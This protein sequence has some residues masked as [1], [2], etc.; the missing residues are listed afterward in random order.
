EFNSFNVIWKD[1][2]NETHKEPSNPYSMTLIQGIQYFKDKLQIR[3]HFIYGR[4]ELICFECEFDKCKPPLASKIDDKDVLLHD[5]YKHLS[6]YPIIQVYWEI[7]ACFMIPYKRTICV[8]RNN[9]PNS[10]PFR[11]AFILSNQR[12]NFNPLPYECDFHKL[13]IIQDTIYAKIIRNNALQKLLHEVIKNDYLI[14]LIPKKLRSIGKEVIEQR[15]DY[16][17]NDQNGELLLNDKIL[18]ILNELRTLYHNDIHKQ[19]GYPLQLHHICAILL[20]CGVRLG[21]IEKE[22]KGGYFISN[23]NTSDYI[24]VAQMYRSDQGCILHFHPSM[25][26]ASGIRSCD[27][28]WISSFKHE[29]EI[30][31]ARSVTNLIDDD[32]DEKTYK[33]LCSWNAKVEDE[34]K[35]TQTILL[36]WTRYDQCLQQALNINA[37]LYCPIDFNIIYVALEYCNGEDVNKTVELLSEFEE[38]KLR[39][40]NKQRYDEEKH[41]FTERRCYSHNVNLFYMFLVEKGFLN[42]QNAMEKLILSTINDGLPFAEKDNIPFLF[43]P[44]LPVPLYQSQCVVHNYEI[45][46]FGDYCNHDCYSYHMIERKYKR[47]C[48]YPSNVKLNGHCVI[49]LIPNNNDSHDVTLL[50][51]GGYPKHTLVMKYESVWNDIENAYNEHKEDYINKWMPLRDND[52]M[53][54]SIGRD[55]D[56]YLGLRAVISGSNNHLLFITYFPNDISVFNLNTFQYEKHSTLP[57][58]DNDRMRYHCFV[59]RESPKKIKIKIYMK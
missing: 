43:L 6:H 19:M 12:P 2:S 22:I 35:Y 26:R 37:I 45:L 10:V 5:T 49:K 3:E 21:N 39:D 55:E 31:F 24:Q 8:Q 41:N 33:E 23:L 1:K 14:D 40:N 28:S 38:W 27:V 13:K 47:I 42:K 29:R 15:I 32:D 4:D 56:D 18:T 17:E 50:S 16:D 57:T 7:K 11:G 30:L 58:N 9:L 46:L 25:R 59:L 52:D 54:I 36:T 34:D 48:S 51:F 44:S 20:H 53:P